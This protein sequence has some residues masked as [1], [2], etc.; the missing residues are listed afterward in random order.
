MNFFS[1]LVGNGGF[2]EKEDFVVMCRM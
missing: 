1:I 2:E